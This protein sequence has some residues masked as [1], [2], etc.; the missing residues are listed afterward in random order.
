MATESPLT[1]PNP[2]DARLAWALASAGTLPFLA[3]AADL[4]FLGGAWTASVQVYAAVI[5]SFLCGVHWGAALL[6]ARRVRP[7][8]LLLASNALALLAWLAAMLPASTGFV[9]FALLFAGLAGIDHLLAR[10]SVWPDWFWRLR[11]TITAVVVAA[12]LLIGLLA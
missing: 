11:M 6:S 1:D 8:A 4:L 2:S 7:A 12:C 5:A 3:G 10:A 9:S